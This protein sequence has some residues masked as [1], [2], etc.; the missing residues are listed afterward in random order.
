[1]LKDV[2]EGNNQNPESFAEMVWSGPIVDVIGTETLQP[3]ISRKF[4]AGYIGSSDT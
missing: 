4:S 1:L 2:I 3:L